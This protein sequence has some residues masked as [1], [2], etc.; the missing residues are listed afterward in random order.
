MSPK[1]KAQ[2]LY[3]M[4]LVLSSDE[5][6]DKRVRTAKKCSLIAVDNTIKALDDVLFPNPFRQYWQ[7]VEN[8]IELL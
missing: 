1:K 4:Y 8:E 3:D 5:T 6:I 7:E 2:E